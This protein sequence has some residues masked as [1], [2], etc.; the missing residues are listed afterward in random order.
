MKQK[1]KLTWAEKFREYVRTYSNPADVILQ[2]NVYANKKEK[3]LY[4]EF[5]KKQTKVI[6]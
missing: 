4:N 3:E 5:H 2:F 1:I 6:K